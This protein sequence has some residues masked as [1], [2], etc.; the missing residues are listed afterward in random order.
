MACFSHLMA[1][2]RQVQTFEVLRSVVRVVQ[3]AQSSA[4]GDVGLL[5]LGN[6]TLQ[7]ILCA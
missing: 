1:D 2:I 4:L 3:L 6:L 7:N 5:V